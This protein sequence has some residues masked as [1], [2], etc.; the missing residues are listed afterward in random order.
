MHSEDGSGPQIPRIVPGRALPLRTLCRVTAL[1]YQEEEEEVSMGGD[2][3]AGIAC[4]EAMATGP[5]LK[6]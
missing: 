6:A 1:L 3:D 5:Q 2:V 4:Q